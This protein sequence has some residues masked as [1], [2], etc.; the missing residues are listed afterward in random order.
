LGWDAEAFY[1]HQAVTDFHG[2]QSG[3]VSHAGHQH[4]ERSPWLAR[5]LPGQFETG[6]N[7]SGYW[8]FF[9]LVLLV[10]AVTVLLAGLALLI[11]RC[12]TALRSRNEGWRAIWWTAAGFPRSQGVDLR[13]D[14]RGSACGHYQIVV[15]R[16]SYLPA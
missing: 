9:A 14:A 4:D 2:H 5:V 1:R 12:A 15:G 11:L 6:V 10:D 7:S 8:V 13:G 3:D 16:G